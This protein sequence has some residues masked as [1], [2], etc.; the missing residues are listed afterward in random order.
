MKL[1]FPTL[2]RV[3]DRWN[4]VS[5]SEIERQQL[6]LLRQQLGIDPPPEGVPKHVRRRRRLRDSGR[7]V[8]RRFRT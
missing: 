4:R 8:Y 5:V 6:R 7:D 1:V 2:M 3:S